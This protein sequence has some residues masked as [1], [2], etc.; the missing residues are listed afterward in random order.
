[1]QAAILLK[2][3]STPDVSQEALEISSTTFPENLELKFVLMEQKC[4]LY[5]V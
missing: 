3:D 4:R 5:W 1:M 2:L